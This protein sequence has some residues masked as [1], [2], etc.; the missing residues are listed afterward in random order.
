M[1]KSKDKDNIPEV[2]TDK[3]WLFLTR[4]SKEPSNAKSEFEYEIF[5]I[6]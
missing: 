1:P 5:F 6:Y 4:K 3:Q 2:M